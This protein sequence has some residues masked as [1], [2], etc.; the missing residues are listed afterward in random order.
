MFWVMMGVV[1][2]I[3]CTGLTTLR[4]AIRSNKV[5][6][7]KTY[8]EHVRFIPSCGELYSI[9]TGFNQMYGSSTKHT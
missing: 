5:K 2:M 4:A 7:C 3:L 6:Y 8:I 9:K 1:V